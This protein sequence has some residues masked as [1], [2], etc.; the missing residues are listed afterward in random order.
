[1]RA[2]ARQRQPQNPPQTK[3]ENHTKPV[4]EHEQRVFQHE[5]P[6][7]E[8]E[9]LQPSMKLRIHVDEHRN[10]SR[11]EQHDA[12]TKEKTPSTKETARN[13]PEIT[14]KPIAKSA[15]QATDTCAGHSK[16]STGAGW[17]L[18]LPCVTSTLP[19]LTVPISSRL[20]T[21]RRASP[22]ALP[23]RDFTSERAGRA[24]HRMPLKSRGGTPQT[25]AVGA[26]KPNARR[27]R[28][29]CCTTRD[30]TGSAHV[31]PHPLDRGRPVFLAGK[32]IPS[33]N[34]RGGAAA[35]ITTTGSVSR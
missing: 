35:A 17:P 1:M 34:A 22:L 28:H 11:G 24:D 19:P 27:W 7:P 32:F 16:K 26:L 15:R 14:A 8:Q 4:P 10:A 31:Q 12:Q 25:A 23:L 30:C 18:P 20:P 29:R 3:T 9:R 2:G 6:V 5:E 21:T 33:T 13:K